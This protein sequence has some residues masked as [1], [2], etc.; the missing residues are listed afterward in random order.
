MKTR[1]LSTVALAA[2]LLSAHPAA[3]AQEPVSTGI[4]TNVLAK[5]GVLTIRSD[6]NGQ[7]LTFHG[8][9]RANIFSADGQPALIGDLQ[10]GMKVTV[11]YGVRG[12]RWYI[13]KVVLPEMRGNAGAAAAAATSANAPVTARDGDITTQPGKKAAVDNDIT[14]QPTDSGLRRSGEDAI[15]DR[16]TNTNRTAPAGGNGR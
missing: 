9:D 6:Q 4:V 2:V 14:T 10:T 15:N 7:P 1:F 11:Q 5:D 3:F 12:Q 8:M 16:G 13:S